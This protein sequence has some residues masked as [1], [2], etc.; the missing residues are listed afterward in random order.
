MLLLH[1]AAL[2]RAADA[3]AVL[4]FA[5]ADPSLPMPLVTTT[6]YDVILVLHESAVGLVGSCIY[7]PSS[8]SAK[9]IDRFVADFRKVLE[10][11]IKQPERPISAINRAL[12]RRS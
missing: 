10:V 9:S 11:M 12:Q 4:S 3:T 5:E 6:T 7:K 8:V 2:R 1:G